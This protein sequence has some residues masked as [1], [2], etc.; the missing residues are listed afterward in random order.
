MNANKSFILV[1]GAAGFIGH[2]LVKKLLK[3]GNNVI[4]IDNLNSYYS[5]SLKD[6]RIEDLNFFATNLES[7][8]IFEKAEINNYSEL[9]SLFSRYKIT[10]IV[11][12]AAQAGV[13]YSIE[14]PKA[15]IQS[16]LVGFSNILE[17]SRRF[18]I[19]NLI[20]A[21][22]SSVYGGNTKLPFNERQQ[23]NHPV[24]LYAATKKANELM[25][26][27]YS[28]LF[29]IPVTGLRFFTV[30]GPWGRPDMAPML[31]ANAIVKGKPIKIFNNGNM[32]RDFTYIEDIVEAIHRCI[33]KP[34]K[35]N[36]KFD[37]NNPDPSTSFAPYKL[38]NIGNSK[39]VNLLSFIELLEKTLNKEAIKI[40]LPMQKGDVINTEADTTKLKSWIGFIPQTPLEEG[41]KLFADWYKD[42][43]K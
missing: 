37:S 39:P 43:Y 17:I 15:Y 28:H 10:I 33:K 30:Y 38:F 22:S 13:R 35:S 7:D 29:G 40:F 41:V 36:H 18:T 21:S 16:N 31:F 25:A 8:W 20:F 27:S 2:S 9:I 6:S 3:K 4:G 5:K 12:L 32:Q 24:S 14:N 34:A 19:Q 23:V 26:H 11:H 1:T 42:F